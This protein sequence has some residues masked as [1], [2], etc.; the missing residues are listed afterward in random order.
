MKFLRKKILFL[1][2]FVMMSVLESYF[3][4]MYFADVIYKHTN[5]LV[6]VEPFGDRLGIRYVTGHA[7]VQRLEA[8]QEEKCIEWCKAGTN[9]AEAVVAELRAVGVLTE[10]VPPAQT[11]VCRHRLGHLRE[12]A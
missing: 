11:V 4:L 8:L 7:V 5:P 10:V 1:I 2:A 6:S 12:T 3:Y 9:I